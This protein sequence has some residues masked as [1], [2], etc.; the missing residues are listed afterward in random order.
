MSEVTEQYKSECGNTQNILS[1]IANALADAEYLGELWRSK[2]D[3]LLEQNERLKHE[4]SY[5]KRQVGSI[6]ENASDYAFDH[7]EEAWDIKNAFGEYNVCQCQGECDG[8]GEDPLECENDVDWFLNV[9]YCEK[10][11]SNPEIK[12]EDLQ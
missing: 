12:I 6:Q 10:C 1:H 2:C 4:I 9:F 5:L 11:T 8:C 7:I 3:I